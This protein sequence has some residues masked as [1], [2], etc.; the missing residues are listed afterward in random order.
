[1][2]LVTGTAEALV[3]GRL[4]LRL[5]HRR[6]AGEQVAD[7]VAG[8]RLVFEQALGQRLQLVGVLG[9]DPP[10][11]G[12][13][14]LDQPADLASIFWAVCSETFCWRDTEWPRNTS[15]WFSP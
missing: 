11:L 13:A 9:Q 7:L 4:V 1:M 10:R 2:L 15:S 14:G 12:E 6:L 8:Q 3:D 5:A